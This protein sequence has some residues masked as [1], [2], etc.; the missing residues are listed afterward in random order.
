M[1]QYSPHK[2]KGSKRTRKKKYTTTTVVDADVKKSRCLLDS[3]HYLTS[4]R[5]QEYGWLKAIV[6]RLCVKNGV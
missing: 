4:T 6:Y 3:S 5:K 2:C 1:R